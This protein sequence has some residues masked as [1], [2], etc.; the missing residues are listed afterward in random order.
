MYTTLRT[1][2]RPNAVTLIRVTTWSATST[3]PSAR[4]VRSGGRIARSQIHPHRRILIL[5]QSLA[6]CHFDMSL[7]SRLALRILHFLYSL[8]LATLSLRSRYLRPA[9]RPLTATRSKV[10]SHLALILAS[11][12][13]DLCI[14]EAQ[15]AFLRCTEKA[16][17]YCRAA[18]IQCLSVY[19]RLGV[20]L[21][22]PD[23]LY[24]DGSALPLTLLR[25]HGSNVFDETYKEGRSCTTTIC[26]VDTLRKRNRYRSR[27]GHTLH[28]PSSS[29]AFTLHF[30]SRDT[31]KPAIAAIADNF[32]RTRGGK[33]ISAN[34][35]AEAFTVSVSELQ[36]ILEGD[37]G[38]GPP[39]DLMIVHNVTLPRRQFT[40][41]ELYS[42]PPWQIRLTEIHYNGFTGI[43]DRLSRVRLR[44]RAKRW[45]MLSEIDFR[46]ALD[47]YSGAEFRLGK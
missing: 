42:F 8:F 45:M 1:R 34:G 11:Q 33:I 47:E 15:E 38:Y 14:S 3:I 16:I 23:L 28:K 22:V 43:R 39:P 46:R 31:G 13:P 12:E 17:A 21:E 20:L 24:L 37:R 29:G 41:L 2:S 36:T 7:L 4:N 25:S 5:S 35:D 26:M 40:P 44:R 9:P 18:G 30:V 32:R 6:F 10:P 27:M 19:D